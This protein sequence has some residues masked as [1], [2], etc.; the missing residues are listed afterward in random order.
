[1]LPPPEP[2]AQH[3]GATGYMAHEL[4]EEINGNI[5]AFYPGATDAFKAAFAELSDLKGNHIKAVITL[6]DI[7]KKE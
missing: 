2:V 1:M 3:L 7:L 4:W 6:L 5:N